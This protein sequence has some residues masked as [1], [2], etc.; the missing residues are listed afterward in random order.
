ML[1]YCWQSE[2]W[3]SNSHSALCDLGR[4]TVSYPVREGAAVQQRPLRPRF[5]SHFILRATWEAQSQPWIFD[6]MC[7]AHSTQQEGTSFGNA[8]GVGREK[9]WVALGSFLRR[10]SLACTGFS[11]LTA[12]ENKNHPAPRF[13]GYQRSSPELVGGIEHRTLGFSW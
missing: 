11:Q 3:R 1:K 12:T 7:R 13:L 4:H 5:N 6:N 10:L 8:I 2:C 9:S